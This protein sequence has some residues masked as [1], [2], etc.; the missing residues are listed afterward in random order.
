MLL[1]S[2]HGHRRAPEDLGPS[3]R[4]RADGYGPGIGENIV[5]Q[6]Y[7]VQEALDAWLDSP[8]HR[9]NLLDP[10]IR[11]VG[12]GIALGGGYDAAPGG[13]RVVWVQSLGRGE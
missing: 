9:R 5:E 6:R 1:R 11:E 10:G 7:S 2:Y 12:L 4:A 3:D 13:Y 8:L